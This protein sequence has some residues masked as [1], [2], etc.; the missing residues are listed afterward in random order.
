M[1]LSQ[2]L[3][4]LTQL[5]VKLVAD[6]DRLHIRAPKG[7]INSELRDA[8]TEKKDALLAWI[9]DNGQDVI[10]LPEIVSAPEQRYQPFPLTDIQY[11]YWV[12]R[13]GGLELGDVATYGYMEFDH[14]NLDIQRL[15]W[16]LQQVIARHDML[17]AIVLPDGQQ[18]ILED[19]PDYQIPVRDLT[20]MDES[21][22]AVH[23][24]EIR[25]EMSHQVLPADRWPLFD[26]RATCLSDTCVRLHLGIDILMFDVGSLQIF[27]NEWQM[28]Y[29]NPAI[30]LP[31]LHLS[32]RDYVL[33][34][35]KVAET[36]LYQRA[37]DYWLAR[38]DTLP[39]APEL[40]LA[41]LPGDIGRSVFARRS[42]RLTPESWQILK[43]RA[44]QQGISPSVTLLTAFSAILNTWSKQPRFTLNVTLFNRLPLH[45]E[46]NAIIGDFTTVNL[47]AIDSSIPGSFIEQARRIH[48][49]LW[50]D[51]EHRYF[52]GV[53]V[54]RALMRQK[55]D[56]DSTLMP[57]VF[58]SALTGETESAGE[59]FNFLGGQPGYAVSQTP[60]VWLDHQVMEMDGTVAFSWDA[61]EAL[62]P[63][64]MLDDM[65]EAYCQLLQQ[66]ADDDT[67]WN[68]P[69]RTLLPDQQRDQRSQVN[70]TAGPVSEELLPTLFLKQVEARATEPAVISPQRTLTYQE[71]YDYANP[72]GH[73]LRE[74]GARVNTLVGVV[75]E[76]GWE[77]VVAVLGTHLAGAAYLPIDPNLPTERRHYLLQEGEVTLV[78]TQSYLAQ[79]LA[80]P[81]SIRLLAVD[82]A[83]LTGAEKPPL[84][85]IQSP[86]DLAYVIYTSGSTGVPKG[87]MIDHRGA[88]N[89]ILDLNER[90]GIGPQDRVLALSNLNFDLSVYD[91]FGILAA[92]GTIVMPDAAAARDPAH[93]LELMDH[94][95]VTLWNSVPALMQMMVEFIAGR[96]NRI[97][98]TALRLVWL[99]GDWIPVTLPDQIKSLW[100]EVQLIS[101]GGATEA[102]IWS[103]LY[104]IDRVE[105]DWSSIPYGKP[106][107]NQTFQVLNEQLEP[108]P[109]W[110]PGQLYI[111]G[112][113]L[114]QGYW[115]DEAKTRAKFITHPQSGERLYQT[116]D[117]G[118]YLPDGNIEF[119]GR[120]DFQVKIR[121]H[122]IE[123]GEIEA[124]LL[125]HQAVKEA[126]VNPIGEP[127]GHRQLVAYVVPESA[128]KSIEPELLRDHLL[129][130]LP[131]YMVPA[132]FM[133]LAT[134]PLT[135]N[136]KVDRKALPI[137]A[138]STTPKED[139]IAPRTPT[140][141]LL[142]DIWCEVLER[143]QVGIHD[144]FFDLGGDS[145]L[146][147]QLTTRITRSFSVE[148]SLRSLLQGATIAQ[149]ARQVEETAVASIDSHLLEQL[150]SEV[151]NRPHD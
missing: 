44:K 47:L 100:S 145:L 120:E 61:V 29:N 103:I 75:M 53:E 105:P 76:K 149:L 151:E 7:A 23:L 17:R 130:K 4:Q 39:P 38:L 114:A 80:W 9:S 106:M 19:M 134:L 140:E 144:N 12:G 146:A 88:V 72:I 22:K 121:G 26:I 8:I 147:T 46:V 59:M 32:F 56:L 43:R 111:G 24:A 85:P 60:Q 116:G 70:A 137:P 25:Q 97:E 94:H 91:I 107:R 31:E 13:G 109:I 108:R 15:N 36:R 128:E 89:T 69:H 142:V 78:L 18:Q 35:K 79:T 96:L 67:A 113:G 66:L 135:P 64:G 27:Y 10:A 83:D 138:A 54:V 16:A 33:A 102:S 125:Q 93:W 2:L 104:P 84:S 129:K 81:E 40:P 28:L 5:G 3:D 118:R 1:S 50:Q 20:P 141:Q 124:T 112:I 58:T 99:S 68:A 52:S 133:V 136:G 77:Q 139:W 55:G 86:T 117:L 143:E 6:G 126:V 98:R 148:L 150:L 62:F 95:Q 110:A 87:V 122:R 30:S 119:L 63:T 65:F 73:W 82:G 71:L 74:R 42:H 34:E 14:S 90:F 115:Q 123:L 11:A 57:V 132:S 101:M 49:Q 37:R 131:D 51:L 92:G 127:K 48:R 21:E 45:Q 41:Q